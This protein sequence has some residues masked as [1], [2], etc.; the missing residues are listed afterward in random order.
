MHAGLG[1]IAGLVSGAG[2]VAVADWLLVD[3][4]AD[5]LVSV[6]VAGGCVAGRVTLAVGRTDDGGS[7]RHLVDY[8]RV[9]A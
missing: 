8:L 4:E 2:R 6:G 3:L 1:V 9:D 7:A 5:S